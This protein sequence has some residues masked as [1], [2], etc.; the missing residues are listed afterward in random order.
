MLARLGHCNFLSVLICIVVLVVETLHPGLIRCADSIISRVMRGWLLITFLRVLYSTTSFHCISLFLENAGNF[1]FI[2]VV[3]V[4]IATSRYTWVSVYWGN[5]NW[6]NGRSWIIVFVSFDIDFKGWSLNHLSQ[7]VV[8][9]SLGSIEYNVSAL[10]TL[11]MLCHHPGLDRTETLWALLRLS[12]TVRHVGLHLWSL[13]FHWTV[14]ALLDWSLTAWLCH[15]SIR[16]HKL[17]SHRLL[18][19]LAGLTFVGG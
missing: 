8:I 5:R 4:N 6:L 15:S 12:A 17:L 2:F 1:S 19:V 7:L 10:T 18:P 13:Q 11:L 3:H 9:I 16:W 14:L